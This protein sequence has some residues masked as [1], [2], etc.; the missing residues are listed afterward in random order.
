MTE[1]VRN[2]PLTRDERIKELLD[3]SAK[4]AVDGIKGPSL[5]DQFQLVGKD[6]KES[7]EEEDLKDTNVEQTP[8]GGRK[9]RIP[10]SRFKTLTSEVKELREEL[11][12]A[13]TLKERIAVLESQIK[14][15]QSTQDDLPDW[16]KEAYGD[17]ENSKQGYKN[18][19]RIMRE[20]MKRSLDAMESER[21]AQE[22]ERE[23]RIKTIESSFDEQM[24]ELESSL[25]REL[26][27]TQKS[28]IM[29]IVGDYSPQEDGKYIA[30]I[31]IEKAYD[32]WQKV[33]TTSAPK[34]N[35]ADIAGLQSSGSSAS[36]SSKERPNWGDW[37]K[38]FS[39]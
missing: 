31:P 20:E 26:T 17:T 10:E 4:D 15:T 39:L 36:E 16:W 23:E 8:T 33:Q 19:V 11:K 34:R 13:S 9:I 21:R 7:G 12:N 6:S 37:R 29:D 25:G 30:Y 35:I 18:Q 2:V 24:D 32:I 3:K 14:S 5:A 38:R 1:E 22:A 28:E 27:A